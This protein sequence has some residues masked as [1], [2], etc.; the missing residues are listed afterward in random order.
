MANQELINYIKESKEKGFSDEEIRKT[1]NVGS[2][3]S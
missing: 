2:F 1:F 3:F